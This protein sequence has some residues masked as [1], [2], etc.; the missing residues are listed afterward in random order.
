[1]SVR[2]ID[3]FTIILKAG[4]DINRSISYL[5]STGS[6][7]DHNTYGDLSKPY[8]TWVNIKIAGGS[9]AKK[10]K[11]SVFQS[12]NPETPNIPSGDCYIADFDHG[13]VEIVISPH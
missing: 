3:I 12:W 9:G 5:L 11:I 13:P 2:S 1:M 10:A 7:S 6:I 8:C 4:I